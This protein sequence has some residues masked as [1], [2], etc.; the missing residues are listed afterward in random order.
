MAV[1]IKFGDFL[2][3]QKGEKILCC[4]LHKTHLTWGK[5]LLSWNLC[6]TKLQNW[7]LKKQ[8]AV[9]YAMDSKFQ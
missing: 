4:R 6:G 5:V 1:V 8:A 7:V 9:S 2:V 3:N